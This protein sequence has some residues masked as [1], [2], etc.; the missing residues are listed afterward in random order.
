ML[1]VFHQLCLLQLFEEIQQRIIQRIILQSNTLFH[2]NCIVALYRPIKYVVIPVSKHNQDAPTKAGD[3]LY[4]LFLIS[5]SFLEN[6]NCL[7]SINR[8]P[9]KLYSL[10]LYGYFKIRIIGICLTTSK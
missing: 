2:L 5:T 8:S 6:E 3:G 4:L 7:S 9:I 1:S 10:I